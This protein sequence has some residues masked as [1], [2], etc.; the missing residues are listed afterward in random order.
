M[1][2]TLDGLFNLQNE[3]TT[4]KIGNGER[5][6]SSI[7]GTLKATVEQVDRSKIEV[8]LKNVAYVPELTRNLFSITKALENGFKLSNKGNIMMLSKGTKMVKF[9]RLQRTKMDSVLGYK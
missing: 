5:L 4:V 6:T 8:T 9:D 3:E 7:V 2:N 1:T